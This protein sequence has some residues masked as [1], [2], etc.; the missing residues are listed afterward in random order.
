MCEI[1]LALVLVATP[2]FAAK[3]KGDEAFEK[4][5]AALAQGDYV[6]A[7]TFFEES[8]KLDPAPG[9]VLN[10]GI[11]NEKQGKYIAAVTHYKNAALAFGKSPA[12]LDAEKRAEEAE[13]KVALVIVRRSPNLPA[14]ARVSINGRQLKAEELEQPMRIDPGPVELSVDADGFERNVTPVRAESGMQ[15]EAIAVQG[16]R[17]STKTVVKT[18]LRDGVSPLRTVGF[19]VGG[20]GVAS[21]LVGG[22]T[23]ALAMGQAGIYRDACDRRATPNVCTQRGY[24]SA[25]SLKTLAPLSTITL[26]A[27]GVLVAAG[28]TL[29][30]VAPKTSTAEKPRAGHLQFTPSFGPRVAGGNLSYTFQ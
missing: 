27:G 26:I 12:H 13:R 28:V 17:L 25:Q 20:V 15:S 8:V 4:G 23:G 14:D 9:T 19:V 7:C 3:S 2:S 24:D 11:C 18:E 30:L 5:R 21:V 16:A 29:I 10:L 1:A 6:G 22:I